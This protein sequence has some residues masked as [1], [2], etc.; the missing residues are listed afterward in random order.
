MVGGSSGELIK[1]KLAGNTLSVG[2]SECFQTVS[3]NS[4]RLRGVYTARVSR[5]D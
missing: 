4:L 3:T 5:A 2:L 1:V